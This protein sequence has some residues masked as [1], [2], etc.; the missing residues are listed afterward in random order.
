MLRMIAATSLMFALATAA[1]AHNAVLIHN[2]PHGFS[3]LLSWEALVLALTVTA[4]LAALVM[5]QAFA[6]KRKAVAARKWSQ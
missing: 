4:G 6:L 5:H 1:S 3:A 2:H